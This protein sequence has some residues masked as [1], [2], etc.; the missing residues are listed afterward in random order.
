MKQ[1]SCSLAAGE[2][3]RTTG[4]FLTDTA[5]IRYRDYT[6]NQIALHTLR[7]LACIEFSEERRLECTSYLQ[8]GSARKLLLPSPFAFLGLL[9]ARKKSGFQ[10][11][12]LKPRPNSEEEDGGFDW[13]NLYGVSGQ[14]GKRIQCSP[15]D[16][17]RSFLCLPLPG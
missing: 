11:P 6:Q 17:H 4:E 2:F 16:A 9:P 1:S 10:S 15:Y 7:R 3:C 13:G 12:D 5:K 14:G 8:T